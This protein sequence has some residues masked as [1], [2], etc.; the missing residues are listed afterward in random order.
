MTHSLDCDFCWRPALP[1][2]PRNARK[3]AARGP[4]ER[5]VPL[6]VD[7]GDAD[8]AAVFARVGR[9]GESDEV[10]RRAK[11]LADAQRDG[12]VVHL[13]GQVREVGDGLRAP[14]RRFARRQRTT[15]T[16]AG[17]GPPAKR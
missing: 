15:T 2:A 9:V 3:E 5:F 12:V 13:V 8:A 17:G 16:H 6:I 7:A 14:R 11:H 4:V 1:N 10:Q